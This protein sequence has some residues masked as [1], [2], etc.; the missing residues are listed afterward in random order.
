MKRRDFL[1][2][3]TSATSLMYVKSVSAEIP[4][5]PVLSGAS[6]AP[7][8]SAID[9]ELDWQSR[10]S[11]PGVVWYHNF[12][13]ADE[14]NRFR[15][16]NGVGMDLDGAGDNSCRHITSDGIS[17]GGCLELD[18][19]TGGTSC[20]NWIR[21]FSPLTGATNGKGTDDPGAGS[22]T[23][24]AW[25]VTQG[26]DYVGTWKDGV[27]S[28]EDYWDHPTRGSGAGW[29][30]DGNEFYIQFRVKMPA[31]RAN[32]S[33][34]PGK[35]AGILLTGNGR[36][37]ITPNQE[38]VIIS[39]PNMAVLNYTN[40]G[41]RSNSALYSDQGAQTGDRQPG[42][43]PKTCPT[44]FPRNSTYCTV[45]PT[46]E[47]VT[48]LIHMKAGHDGGNSNS[49]LFPNANN[50]T[51][52]RMWTANSG[53]T[54]YTKVYDKTD[55]VWSFGEFDSTPYGWNAFKPWAYMNGVNAVEGW[56]QRY[57]EIIFSKEFIPCPQV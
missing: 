12:A 3:A 17:G 47:W 4:C 13:S 34:P 38:L 31:S 7:L 39:N 36:S 55:F 23:P 50:D 53:D 21:P 41:N 9:A 48:V 32:P 35:L 25:N 18:I 1:I 40:F 14:V 51:T 28:H 52:L 46:D 6:G 54:S 44:G 16:A 19:P 29:G 8:C 56:Y 27:Y 5:P 20:G 2:G 33:N 45:Y 49:P 24:L 26:S 30:S 10:I 43:D 57:D 11:G 22:I 42:G 37:H 15:R